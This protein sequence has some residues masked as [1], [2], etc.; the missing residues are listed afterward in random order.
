LRPGIAYR[1]KT[2]NRPD[3]RYTNQFAGFHSR[4]AKRLPQTEKWQQYSPQRAVVQLG[5]TLEWG[6]YPDDFLKLS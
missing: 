6:A 2:N 3:Q 1:G 5:R 4:K